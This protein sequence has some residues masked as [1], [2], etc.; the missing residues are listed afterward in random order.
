MVKKRILSAKVSGRVVNINVRLDEMT[1]HM[2]DISQREATK[3]AG[4]MFLFCFIVPTL[5]WGF[6]LSQLIDPKDVVATANNIMANE[7][8]FRIGITIE[9]VMSVG[10]VLL[11]AALYTILKKVDRLLALLGLLLKLVEAGLVGANVLILFI[12][13]Q[14]LNGIESLTAFSLGQMQTPVGLLLNIHTALYSI[15]M[16]FLGLNMSVFFYLFLKSQYIPR[17]LAVFGILSFVLILIH[18]LGNILAPHIASQLAFQTICFLP[19][20]IAELV[21]SPWLL[22]KGVKDQQT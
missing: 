10:L 18:S 12:A 7:L 5:N 16:V 3:V 13:F 8:L 11:A 15:P 14:M 1:K 19:S 2:D 17:I 22:V 21:V 9:L 4:V 20:C 6:L